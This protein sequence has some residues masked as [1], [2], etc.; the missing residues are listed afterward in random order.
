MFEAILLAIVF[1]ICAGCV[2]GLIPGVH[3]NLVAV[4]VLSLATSMLAGVPPLYLGAFIIAMAITHT[5][6]DALPG[7]YL[8]APDS[9]MALSVLPGHRLL[10]RGKGHI[11]VMCTVIGSYFCLILALT[12]FPLFITIMPIIYEYTRMYLGWILIAIMA[13]M[14][15]R[16]RTWRKKLLSL[17]LFLLAGSLGLIVLNMHSLDQPLFPLLSGL[18]GCSILVMS[19]QQQTKIPEQEH[20]GFLTLSKR[21]T[22]RATVAA[23]I[24]GFIAAFLPGFG[25]SQAAIIAKEFA[26][27]IGDEGFLVLVGG[28]NTAKVWVR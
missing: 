24:V 6:L 25:S 22:A 23:T 27:K 15:F 14:I 1:G 16:E 10:L 21:K 7:I 19:L 8:G 11:A 9:D 18:F 13:Y 26:G 28:I 20:E 17:T 5:Y 2:T 3:I 4:V 12:L